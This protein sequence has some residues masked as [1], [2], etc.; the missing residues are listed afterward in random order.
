MDLAKKNCTQC[1]YVFFFFFCR[2]LIATVVVTLAEGQKATPMLHSNVV[3]KD[4]RLSPV[5]VFREGCGLEVLGF[6]LPRREV[7]R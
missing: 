3:D 1:L 5:F 6:F 4:E 2:G 7:V